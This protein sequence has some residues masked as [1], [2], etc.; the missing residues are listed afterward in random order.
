MTVVLVDTSIF[1]NVLDVPGR[2]QQRLIVL[3]ELQQRLEATQE[4]LLPI[5]AIIETGNHIGHLPDGRLRRQAAERFVVEVRKALDGTAP[6]VPARPITRDD[7]A[8]WLEG[9]PDHAMAERGL[10][11]VS[12]IAEWER[13]RQLSQGRRRIEIWSLDEHLQGYAT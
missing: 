9:F 6:W 1:L 5:A 8:D 3:R 2:N 10:G 13:Q 12:I 11:D 4:L 7:I